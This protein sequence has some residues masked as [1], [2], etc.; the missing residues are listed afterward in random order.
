MILNKDNLGGSGAAISIIAGGVSGLL[1]F[2]L[3]ENKEARETGYPYLMPIST[4]IL[5]WLFGAM[6][7]YKGVDLSDNT[8]SFIGS[9]I[10]G[11]HLA[12]FAAHIVI[13]NRS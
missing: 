4:D 9:S 1:Y 13:R 7:I 6:L 8:I 2:N 3:M 10:V 5:A 12:K 11:I